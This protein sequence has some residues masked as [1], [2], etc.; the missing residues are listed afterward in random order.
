MFLEDLY[1]IIGRKAFLYL[2]VRAFMA[3]LADRP[4]GYAAL[5]RDLRLRVMPHWHESYATSGGRT[6]DVDNGNTTEWFPHA[7]DPGDDV[8]GQLEF[9]LK[10]D[11]TSPEILRAVFAAI[12]DERVRAIVQEKPTGIY[13]RRLWFFFEWL[14]GRTLDL[15]DAQSGNYIPLLD[16]ARCVTTR[17][18]PSRRHR[19][20]DNLLGDARFCPLIRRTAALDA[21]VGDRLDQ[22]AHRL[23]EGI[24]PEL[25]QRAVSYLFTR[26]TMSSFAIERETPSSSRAERFIAALHRAGDRRPFGAPELLAL[27]R[28]IVEPRFAAA[29]YRDTQNYVG[30]SADWT[31]EIV[32][33]VCPKPGDVE[34]LMHGFFACLDRLDQPES[35]VDAVVAAA[36]VAFGFVFIH[37]FDDGNGRIHRYLVHHVLARRG[38]TPPGM[39]LPVSAVMLTDGAAYDRCLERF[40]RP[41]LRRI[42]YRLDAGGEMTVEGD[43]A[44]FYRYPDLTVMA[45][46]LY[47]CVATSIGRDLPAELDFLARYGRIKNAIMNR[48]DMPD[49]L[50]D[51]FIRLVHQNGGT[52]S[53]GKR[54]AHFA[55]LTDAEVADLERIIAAAVPAEVKP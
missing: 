39:I 52:L 11:G 28:A 49:R 2:F 37:P 25:L 19:V 32:H 12:G 51:L 31:R 47:A 50:I 44:S 45:E 43:T 38:F 9:A 22:A 55:M 46:Y 27:Q 4:L 54:V 40:S 13:R 42:D 16:P 20:I 35:G 3:H 21:F 48:L 5:I 6:S 18:A 10:Y 29:G 15:P 30:A 14:T 41:L 53:R 36:A 1:V 7:Y 34:A 23:V 17:G 33:Y 26:E 24:S 8:G